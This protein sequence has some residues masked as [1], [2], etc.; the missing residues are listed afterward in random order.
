M[1]VVFTLAEDIYVSISTDISVVTYN[2]FD[3]YYS[4]RYFIRIVV[5]VGYFT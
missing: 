3:G 5:T 2:V 1:S 4:Y